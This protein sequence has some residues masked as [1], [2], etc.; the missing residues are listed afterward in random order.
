MLSCPFK[1]EPNVLGSEFNEGREI[2]PYVTSDIDMSLNLNHAMK[3]WNTIKATSK[4]VFLVKVEDHVKD[5]LPPL[6]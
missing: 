1:R 2:C 3:H 4:A 5:H 6:L